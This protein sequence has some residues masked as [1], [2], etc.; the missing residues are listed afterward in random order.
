MISGRN[1]LSAEFSD[2]AARILQRFSN[3]C[4]RARQALAAAAADVELA[5]HLVE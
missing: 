2:S 5:A 3:D 1:G 4:F